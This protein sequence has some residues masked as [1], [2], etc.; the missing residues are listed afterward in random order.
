[1][2]KLVRVLQ[3]NTLTKVNSLHMTSLSSFFSAYFTHFAMLGLI[4]T[5][6]IAHSGLAELRMW[7]EEKIGARLY[8][9]IFALVSIPLAVVLLIYFFN[10]RYDGAQLWNVQGVTGVSEFV[11]IL[12]AISFLFLY[13][14]TFNLTEVAALKKPEVHLFE[15]GIIR[16][17]RHPQMIGQCLWGIAHALWLGTS[18][19]LV[20]AIALVVYHLFAVWHGDQRLFKRYGDAFLA[21]KERTS[22]IPFVAIAQ[23]RQQLV[24]KE[25]VR[26]AYIGVAITIVLFRWLH[27]IAITASANV[28]W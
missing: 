18:F 7:A 25:F 3:S 8:R 28:N 19:T 16:I 27:P 5:F 17:C 11:L 13:P 9:V 15:T 12:S 24:L 20:T 14:A 10:H 1:M 2:A 6:A 21:V 22:V 4:L 26:P 23:G